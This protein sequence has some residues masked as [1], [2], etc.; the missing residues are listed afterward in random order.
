MEGAED[1]RARDARASLAAA[2]TGCREGEGG[3]RRARGGAGQGRSARRGGG[4]GA[5][6]DA[7][8]GEAEAA[9]AEA[10]RETRR[11]GA[12]ARAQP[13]AGDAG[14]EPEAEAEA[15]R[16]GGGGASCRRG[17]DQD[18]GRGGERR[19]GAAE[20]TP[21]TDASLRHPRGADERGGARD[22]VHDDIIA[23]NLRYPEPPSTELL[24]IPTFRRS[25]RPALRLGF[26]DADAMVFATSSRSRACWRTA[27]SVC[28]PGESSIVPPSGLPVGRCVASNG[29]ASPF[30]TYPRIVHDHVVVA[31]ALGRPPRGRARNP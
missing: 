13:A 8:G 6:H 29:I 25:A 26:T 19:K 3:D 20:A 1:A 10:R 22:D 16:D 30:S 23:M 27:A 17:E 11:G 31:G 28:V 14:G 21:P 9:A 15:K 7:G 2:E 5:P 24:G 18:R 4:G 12:A